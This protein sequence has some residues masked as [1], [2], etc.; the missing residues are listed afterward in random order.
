MN[1]N[2]STTKAI[3]FDETLDYSSFFEMQADNFL[4]DSV[5]YFGYFV[6]VIFSFVFDII[7]VYKKGVTRLV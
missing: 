1:A 6:I 3:F 5:Q 7:S 2:A 4:S